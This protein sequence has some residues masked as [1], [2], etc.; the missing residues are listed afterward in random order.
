MSTGPANAHDG[1]G[2]Q[3]AL[4]A[5]DW[6]TGDV[7]D[8]SLP[9]TPPRLAAAAALAGLGAAADPD[10]LGRHW[11]RFDAPGGTGWDYGGTLLLELAL[12]DSFRVGDAPPTAHHVCVYGRAGALFPRT[13]RSAL[14]SLCD[15]WNAARRWPT[16]T[17]TPQH[18]DSL[19]FGLA[20]TAHLPVGAGMPASALAQWLK[21]MAYGVGAM[22]ATL[23]PAAERNE[24]RFGEP[25]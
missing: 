19:V 15:Q 8:L 11:A 2:D 24:E 6:P 5:L 13:Q 3:N 22:F 20:A 1:L 23:L 16:A 10:R 21:L 4:D 14:L 7:D 18:S 12:T 25:G 17:V 9:V